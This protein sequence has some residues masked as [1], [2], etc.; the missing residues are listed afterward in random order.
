M[1]TIVL[2]AVGAAVGG[3]IG[4]PVG[5]VVGR[6]LG[7]M[8]GAYVDQQIFGPDDQSIVGP[9]FDN[10]KILTSREGA[11]IPRVYGRARIAGEIIWATRFEEVQSTETQSQGGKGGGGPKTT[12]TSFSYFGNFAIGL[13]EGEIAHIGRIWADGRLLEQSQMVIR[14]YVGSETQQ[15]DSLI[16][17]KQ[18]AGNAPAYRGQAYLVF[19]NFPLEDYGNR[20]PQI[21]VEVI[22]TLGELERKLFAVNM[23]PG[24]TEFGYDPEPVVEAL[25]EVESSRLN[26]H[27][28]VAETDFLASLDELLALC[29]NL[30]QIALV[31][32]W[33][34]DDLRAGHC[35]I[36]PKVEVASRNMEQGSEWQV[37]G[38]ARGS[39][40]LVSYRDGNPAYGGTPSDG[41]IVRA[42]QEI[43]KRGIKVC[44]NPFVM[45]DVAE[46]NGL[47]DPYGGAEQAAY[48][49]RGRITCH[50]APQEPGSPDGTSVARQQVVALVGSAQ[51]NQFVP[52]QEG[53]THQGISDWG[54]RRMILHYAHL[55]IAAGGVDMFLIGSEL[56]GLTSLRAE[57]QT[58][59]FVEAL[60]DLADDVATVVSSKCL[61][62]YGADWSEFFGFHPADGSG[63]VYFNL[64]PLWVSSSIGAVGIDNYV[65]L[66]D[67]RSSGSP[68]GVG[69]TGSDAAM[70][71]G[72][73]AGGEGFD[74]YYASGF[75]RE[76]GVRTAITDSL[77]KP[78]I[79]RY[80]DLISW[81]QNRHY[82]RRAGT[83]LATPGPWLAQSKP[84]IF[85]E[86]GCPAVNKG[87]GQPNVFVDPK[88][89]ESLL[90]YFSNGGRNDQMQSAFIEAHQQHWLGDG[91]DGSGSGDNAN[92]PESNQYDGTMVD[93]EQAQFWA[94]DARPYPAFPSEVDIWS[95]SP[96]WQTG[97]WLNGRLG[98]VRLADL[99]AE[100][101]VSNGIANYNV[102]QVTGIVDGYVVAQQASARQALEVLISLFRLSVFEDAGTVHFRSPGLDPVTI[103]MPR[104]IVHEIDSAALN[105]VTEQ[106][107]DLP[108][109]VQLAHIDP[110]FDFQDT[111]TAASRNNRNNLRQQSM[112]ASLIIGRDC[113]SPLLEAWLHARWTA[114]DT[115]AFGV[116]RAF[117]HLTVGDV[118]AFSDGPL[119]P[120]WRI[121]RIES[122]EDLQL[123]ALAIEQGEFES[124]SGWEGQSRTHAHHGFGRPLCRFM[125]L[126]HLPLLDGN[127]GNCLAVTASPWPGELAVYASPG[128]EGHSYQQSTGNA[129]FIGVL[130][131]ELYATDAIGRWDRRSHPRIKLHHGKVASLS[132]ELVLN[133]GNAL[134]VQSRT[135]A[136]EILQFE[137]AELVG[138][139]TYELTSLL[140]GQAGTEQE[141]GQGA[142]IGAAVIVLNQAVT[143]LAGDDNL[144]GLETNWLVGPVGKSLDGPEFSLTTFTPGY[145]SQLPYAPVHL[146]ARSAPPGNVTI[147]WIRR[148]RIN[149]DDWTAIEIP[150]SEGSQTYHVTLTD[151]LQRSFSATSTEPQLVL[152][153]GELIAAF[154]TM[155]TNLEISVAQRSDTVG[156]GPQ[157]SI[158]TTL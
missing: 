67:W 55:A 111:Q 68:D 93:F 10:A 80:K 125:D 79:Y 30:K 48:P 4:G 78:W 158:S 139:Q 89:S 107:S 9:Q 62:S 152:S 102:E 128:N 27:Q 101:L 43:K 16:E 59:P 123:T 91:A 8:A 47:P 56:R 44:L 96:N 40:G 17:A 151:E 136:Y 60:Q 85:T 41:S 13:C 69:R 64:D 137:G 75:D 58:F 108:T 6:T 154:G 109:S 145:R 130:E 15:P 36:K 82:D 83:E 144:R 32:S 114:R 31:V 38:L 147:N 54:Y 141:A 24:A 135:G 29:P 155:P 97:H 70:L 106:E 26:T 157:T 100:L 65:P 105:Y 33:F 122:G 120:A 12:V 73:V 21:A 119:A 14:R 132:R 90:P 39:V 57:N 138:A 11:I 34:G 7:A 131:T 92:N 99:L 71:A 156:D 20:I 1:A 50:P 19:E 103:L 86:I 133:G 23:I 72:Q 149:S 42:I 3:A 77:G 5:A 25:S 84:I 81:W 153:H 35:Q 148:D 45:M 98:M 52:G 124:S 118:I 63:D 129:A 66:S 46:E 88:S 76:Y 74:W 95:D 134:A 2:Q 146:R 140:R 143:K 22:R 112:S 87:A 115:V 94:W 61:I 53:V 49:W 110:N 104:D 121:S 150:L 18:G 117:S 28:S 142:A 51:V 113:A 127:G 116:S 126:P 37:A